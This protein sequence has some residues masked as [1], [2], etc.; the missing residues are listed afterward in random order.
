MKIFREAI[1][2]LGIYLLGEIISRWF[3]LPIPG[4]ILG[5]LILLV[6]LCTKVI[7]VEKVENISDFFLEHLA[8]FFIPAGVGLLNSFTS[9]KDSLL[10]IILLCVVTT[11][12]VIVTTGL[13]V[14]F[15]MNLQRKNIKKGSESK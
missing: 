11:A 7:K 14:Q 5:M 15:I 9:I 12:I 10:L 2:V 8:F 3:S 6:L 4:N 1:I 13:I